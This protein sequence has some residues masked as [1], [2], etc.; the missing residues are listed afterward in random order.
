MTRLGYRLTGDSG[1][2]TSEEFN[3]IISAA[4]GF[5]ELGHSG[6][7]APLSRFANTV[8]VKNNTE[9]NANFGEVF[10]VT[11]LVLDPHFVPPGPHG[12]LTSRRPAFRYGPIALTIEE[13]SGDFPSEWV[14][15]AQPIRAGEIGHAYID[16]IFP[17]VIDWTF[18]GIDS[19]E[20]ASPRETSGQ[21]YLRSFAHGG[22]VR[23]VAKGDISVSSQDVI[24]EKLP[25]VREYVGK[26]TEL[27]LPGETG[28]VRRW[29]KP[30]AVY[31]PGAESESDPPIDDECFSRMQTIFSGD[32]VHYQYF[33]TGFEITYGP[34]PKKY[35][36]KANSSIS[37]GNSGL[38][39]RWVIDPEATTAKGAEV[40]TEIEDNCYARMGDVGPGDWVIYEHFEYGFEITQAECDE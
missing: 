17:A 5:R 22:E 4:R 37:K 30:S 40:E 1:R 29:A 33:D 8:L 10:E 7:R 18:G 16:G 28:T 15:L 20:W 27:I 21:R 11:G 19:H 13:L 38:V 35:L 2:H 39:T 34:P 14:S 26:A 6:S 3:D 31:F 32:W 12:A 9:I 23:I 24:V 36:G 25:R